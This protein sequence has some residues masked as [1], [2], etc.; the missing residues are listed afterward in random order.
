MIPNS[1][2]LRK[3]MKIRMESGAIG[4][5]PKIGKTG[6]PAKRKGIG[7]EAPEMEEVWIC[8]TL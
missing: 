7:A 8:R 5:Y 3:I 1:R 2:D 4:K 6:E